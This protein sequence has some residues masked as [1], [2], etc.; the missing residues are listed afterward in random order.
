MSFYPLRHGVSSRLLGNKF[1]FIAFGIDGDCLTVC[2]L[3]A[4][5]PGCY[6]CLD[7]LLQISLDRS[8]AVLRRISLFRD[9]SLAV[10]CEDQFYVPVFKTRLELLQGQVD[11]PEY[12]F[13]CQR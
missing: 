2:D 12:V 3:S 4:Y 9:E 13:F 6:G 8:C 5:Y 11:E 10:F 1:L 7:I